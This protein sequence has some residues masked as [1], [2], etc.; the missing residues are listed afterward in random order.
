MQ[1]A[2]TNNKVPFYSFAYTFFAHKL[3]IPSAS[4]LKIISSVHSFVF[5]QH[6]FKS[7]VCQYD[8]CRETQFKN[9]FQK[10]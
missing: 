7:T 9:V 1:S 6:L 8:V 3:R 10:T 4:P 5:C 2:Y